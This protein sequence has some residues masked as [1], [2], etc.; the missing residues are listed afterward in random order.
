MVTTKPFYRP[1]PRYIYNDSLAKLSGQPIAIS[2]MQTLEAAPAPMAQPSRCQNCGHSHPQLHNAS[3][4]NCFF[5]TIRRSGRDRLPLS[6]PH[7]I[8]VT[9]TQLL[10]GGARSRAQQLRDYIWD[11]F[12]NLKAEVDMDRD[13]LNLHRSPKSKGHLKE[14]APLPWLSWSSPNGQ[15]GQTRNKANFYAIWDRV[16][17]EASARERAAAAE[18]WVSSVLLPARPE[19]LIWSDETESDPFVDHVRDSEDKV[20]DRKL[21]PVGVSRWDRQPALVVS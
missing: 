18:L 20:V 16:M 13:T 8:P 2:S 15:S 19:A 11:E 4:A 6:T 9:S 10:I 1:K 12:E 7:S 14:K 17:A 5:I 21:L 3:T